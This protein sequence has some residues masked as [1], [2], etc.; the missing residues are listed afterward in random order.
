[1]LI[2]QGKYSLSNNLSLSEILSNGTILPTDSSVNV[3]IM[4]LFFSFKSIFN[5]FPLES[6]KVIFSSVM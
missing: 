2:I 5:S 1:M 6:N 3:T 4:N